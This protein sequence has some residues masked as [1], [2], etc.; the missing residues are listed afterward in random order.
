MEALG[1]NPCHQISEDRS[2]MSNTLRPHG[3]YNPWNSP[4]QNTAVG[5]LSLLQGTFPTQGLN[6]GLPHCRRILYQLSHKGSPACIQFSSVQLLSCVQLFATPRTTAQQ[7]SLSITNSQ[8]SLRLTSIESVM[9]SSHRILCRPLL[10]LPP[11]PPSI[12]VFSNESTLRM[13]WPKYWS[14][15]LASFLPKKSQ[16]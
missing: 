3:L 8:S 15:T 7:A 4:G 16:G 6:P 14:F 2:V 9:P 11:I 10:L 12:R 13:R 1:L 5:S